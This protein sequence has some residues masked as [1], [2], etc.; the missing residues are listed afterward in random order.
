ME[1][2]GAMRHIACGWH[3]EGCAQHACQLLL[4]VAYAKLLLHPFTRTWW[5]FAGRSCFDL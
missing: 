3:S 4:L 5:P 2:V 1:M